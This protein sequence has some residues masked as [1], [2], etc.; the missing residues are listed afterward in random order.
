MGGDSKLRIFL[1]AD[2][3]IKRHHRRV[4]T[5]KSFELENQSSLI[6]F[7]FP[8]SPRCSNDTMN[9]RRRIEKLSLVLPLWPR[10]FGFNLSLNLANLG[11]LSNV[12]HRDELDRGNLRGELNEPW[13]L[14]L[15]RGPTFSFA[16]YTAPRPQFKLPWLS[17]AAVAARLLLDRGT[18]KDY[19][20]PTVYFRKQ[21][22]HLDDYRHGS[23]ILII[24]YIVAVEK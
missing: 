20:A 5:V 23:S 21:S 8:L 22:E 4:S 11:S 15:A 18:A 2:K 7:V 9:I 17:A 16:V 13:N 19:R 10:F 3:P 14:A 6:S 1:A 24:D 12:F